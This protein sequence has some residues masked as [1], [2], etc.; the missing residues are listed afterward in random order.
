MSR[1]SELIYEAMANIDEDL[2]A[3]ASA[4]PDVKKRKF[5]VKWISVAVC[6]VLIVS[7]A[8]AV[9]RT[10]QPG[11]EYDYSNIKT[12]HYQGNNSGTALS[13]PLPFDEICK[14]ED[15]LIEFTVTGDYRTEQVDFSPPVTSAA[16]GADF[17][18]DLPVIPIR[19]DEIVFQKEGEFDVA[20]FEEVWLPL[21]FAEY[22][23][24]YVKGG[25]FL[26]FATVTDY[27]EPGFED[28]PMDF[29]IGLAVFFIDEN[30]KLVPFFDRMPYKW[31]DGIDKEEFID[32]VID[33]RNGK[34]NELA[35]RIRE[36]E[37]Q[38]YRI[39]IERISND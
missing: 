19:I 20:G 34:E 15:C 25:R 11:I 16:I 23:G 29:S 7:A 1:K 8:F 32:A 37:S 38:T 28:T 22:K 26:A 17:L 30:E 3:S 24:A 5:P 36:K 10:V 18:Y 13:V 39:E 9:W 33:I 31:F 12:Y 35:E 21:L 14:N 4:V 27:S 6:F 2:I